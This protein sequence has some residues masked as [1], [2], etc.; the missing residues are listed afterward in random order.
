MDYIQVISEKNKNSLKRV[1]SLE[2]TAK[3]EVLAFT[4]APY[5]M[6]LN[7]TGNEEEFINLKRGL[8]CKSIYEVE[9]AKKLDFLKKIELFYNAG[10][11]VRIVNVLPLKFLIFDERIVMVTLEDMLTS[12]TRL[13]TLVIE[14]SAFTRFFKSTFENYWKHAMTLE[15]F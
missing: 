9:D 12:R 13:T 10:E 7:F 2:R 11:E 15:E 5:A 6:S 3:N 4:K 1:E 14:H 8:K